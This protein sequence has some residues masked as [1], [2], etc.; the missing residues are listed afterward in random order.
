MDNRGYYEKY[1]V[2]N[3]ETG[4]QIT[5]FR[6]VLIP[7]RDEYAADALAAYADAVENDN[8]TLA[9]DLREHLVAS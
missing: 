4:E 2:R 7:G 6:F 5:E 8:P 9:N 1:Y 3:N